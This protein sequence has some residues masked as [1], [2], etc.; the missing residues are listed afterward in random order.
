VSKGVAK[1][2]WAEGLPLKAGWYWLARKWVT[3]SPWSYIVTDFSPRW[4]S[5]V[6][7]FNVDQR[8]WTVPIKK[9]RERPHS[10]PRRKP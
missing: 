3:D 5:S 7:K 10:A 4:V 6:W 2:H 1:P 9:P 8:W